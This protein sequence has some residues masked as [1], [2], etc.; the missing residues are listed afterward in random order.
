MAS[1]DMEYDTDTVSTTSTA[2]ANPDEYFTI[3]GIMSE[4]MGQYDDGMPVMKYLV[5]WENYPIEE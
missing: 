2:E 3:K 5:E 4:A 1:S